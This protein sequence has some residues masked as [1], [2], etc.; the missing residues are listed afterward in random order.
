MTFKELILEGG[1]STSKAMKE[2]S[3]DNAILK[4]MGVDN[5]FLASGFVPK[6]KFKEIKKI[7]KKVKEKNGKVGYEIPYDEYEKYVEEFTK[8]VNDYVKNSK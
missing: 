2:L 6:S 3:V 1:S 7:A 8:E 5:D 4:G